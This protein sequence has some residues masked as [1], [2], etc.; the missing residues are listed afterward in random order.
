MVAEESFIS[1]GERESRQTH[2]GAVLWF[3]GL[4][5]SGKTALSRA[6]ERRW[7]ERGF[8]A[9]ALDGDQLRKGLCAD[10]GYSD[11]DRKTNMT[12]VA[13]Q[14]RTFLDAGFLTLVSLISPFEESRNQAKAIVGVDRFF[15]IYLS[16]PLEVCQKRDS[17]KLYLRANAGELKQFT[18]ISSRY[19][20]PVH[21]ELILDSSQM[22]LEEEIEVVENFI[23]EKLGIHV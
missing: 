18:G 4:S 13:Y 10:L 7:F 17:K 20:P 19:E 11:T 1:R 6:L 21:P 16:C 9:I 2:R 12:R 22:A 14:A 23:K 8:L 3:T 15:E 5:G